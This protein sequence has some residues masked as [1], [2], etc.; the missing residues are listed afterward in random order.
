MDKG[1]HWAYSKRQIAG[2]YLRTNLLC[3]T[4]ASL[5]IDLIVV[6]AREPLGL[7]PHTPL[8]GLRLLKLFRAVSCYLRVSTRW[9]VV[10]DFSFAKLELI[11]IV[12]LVLF[13]AHSLACLWPPSRHEADAGTPCDLC[14]VHDV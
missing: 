9:L 5:P 11:R 4:L 14:G 8:R 3:D 2:H 1:A 10:I 7:A 12:L 6:A 13:M